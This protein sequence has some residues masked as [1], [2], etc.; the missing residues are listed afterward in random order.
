[1]LMMCMALQAQHIEVVPAQQGGLACHSSGGVFLGEL[2]LLPA[3]TDSLSW[4]K[5]LSCSPYH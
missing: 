2:Q 1:M 4:S 3:C 5:S